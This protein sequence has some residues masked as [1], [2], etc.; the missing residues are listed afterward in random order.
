MASGLRRPPWEVR[1]PLEATG[2]LR[3]FMFVSLPCGDQTC[4]LLGRLLVGCRGL[5]SLVRVAAKRQTAVGC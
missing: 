3:G 4:L 2:K 1:R 5:V